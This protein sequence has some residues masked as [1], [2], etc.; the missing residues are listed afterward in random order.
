MPEKVVGCG[1]TLFARRLQLRDA[2]RLPIGTGDGDTVLTGRH[3]RSGGCLCR[4][5]RIIGGVDLKRLPAKLR[6]CDRPRLK[7]AD[8]LDDRARALIPSGDR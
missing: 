7:A 5:V 6:R 1:H 2:H 3:D 4:A 8:V